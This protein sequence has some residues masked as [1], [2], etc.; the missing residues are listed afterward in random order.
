MKKQNYENEI[1]AIVDEVK[2]FIDLTEDDSVWQTLSDDDDDDDDE[3]W[4][5]DDYTDITDED[6]EV[7]YVTFAELKTTK[8]LL[9]ISDIEAM[10]GQTVLVHAPSMPKMHNRPK[11]CFGIRTN[12]QSSYIILDDKEF[13]ESLFTDGTIALY[14][15]SL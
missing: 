14:R 11:E 12:C 9:S 6:G 3:V 4:E 1:D 5:D 15:M 8:N 10:N 7:L 13:D 2:D